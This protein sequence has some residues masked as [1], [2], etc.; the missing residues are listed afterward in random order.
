MADKRAYRLAGWALAST[1]L[2][3]FLLFKHGAEAVPVVAMIVMCAYLNVL[4]MKLLLGGFKQ[5]NAKGS[6]ITIGALL[7]NLATL[8]V[9]DFSLLTAVVVWLPAIAGIL[10]VRLLPTKN[11]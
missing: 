9:V 1:C 4:F 10:A 6:A 8:Y 11:D 3:A 7:T 2:A 5:R